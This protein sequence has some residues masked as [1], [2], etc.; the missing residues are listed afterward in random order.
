M[1]ILTEHLHSRVYFTSH[2]Y[3]PSRETNRTPPL[4][5]LLPQVKAAM[6]ELLPESLDGKEGGVGGMNYKVIASGPLLD[7]LGVSVLNAI[8]TSAVGAS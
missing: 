4:A 5:S 8:D 3:S 7:S 2:P 1:R 6:A